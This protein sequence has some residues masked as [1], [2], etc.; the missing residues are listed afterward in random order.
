MRSAS[1]RVY[2][3]NAVEIDV[4]W[5]DL[6]GDPEVPTQVIYQVFDSLT[7]DAVSDQET[8]TNIG[9]DMSFV[10]PGDDLPS[11]VKEVRSLVI[12]IRATFAAGDTH[13]EQVRVDV[14]KV[15]EFSG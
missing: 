12:Q 13:T 1:T 8:L 3:G 2:A 10:V 9:A 7:G 14:R 4:E 5:H 6:S 11:G 15:F